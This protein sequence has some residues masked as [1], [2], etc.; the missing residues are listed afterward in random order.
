[1]DPPFDEL[2]PYQSPRADPAAA[3]PVCEVE[4]DPTA[5]LRVTLITSAPLLRRIQLSG[6][7]VADIEWNAN[8][9]REY[10]AVNGDK[11]V[12]QHAVSRSIPLFTFQFLAGGTAHPVTV[13]TL[14]R[15]VYV[16]TAF[17]VSI[18]GRP[19]YTEGDCSRLPPR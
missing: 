12:A 15:W 17:R 19:V 4:H 6:R 3:L 8:G 14:V 11:V 18:D 16:T 1:M 10:V 13:E 7:F 2:N 9:F 5:P